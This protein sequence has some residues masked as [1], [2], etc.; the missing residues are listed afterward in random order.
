MLFVGCAI[1]SKGRT[2]GRPQGSRSKQFLDKV[3]KPIHKRVQPSELKTLAFR[4]FFQTVQKVQDNG[5]LPPE[6]A[7]E[8]TNPIDVDDPTVVND[9]CSVTD[10]LASESDEV[11]NEK[12]VERAKP[13]RNAR[14]RKRR[15]HT[16]QE[17]NNDSIELPTKRPAIQE[18]LDIWVKKIFADNMKT[19]EQNGVQIKDG[20]LWCCGK[21]LKKHKSTV[22]RHLRSKRHSRYQSEKKELESTD[23]AIKAHKAFQKMFQKNLPPGQVLSGATC[24]SAQLK[25]R[26]EYTRMMIICG[27][28]IN[29]FDKMKTY[30]RRKNCDITCSLSDLSYL[31]PAIREAELATIKKE[32][33]DTMLGSL[34]SM[35]TDGTGDDGAE[36]CNVVIRWVH[37]KTFQ[38]IQRCV[39][40]SMLGHPMT[41]ED[42]VK[43]NC[44]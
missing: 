23:R 40:L 33:S 11:G 42:I 9:T 38:P 1:M 20:K 8:K 26:V 21:E 44:I 43:V 29:K 3:C 17:K 37:V 13:H 16:V 31:I 18:P 4:N 28:P 36:M 41:A 14:P 19:F 39:L 25:E 15:I 22:C 5:N 35:F 12:P 24:S 34:Y 2:A 6:G 7:G 10:A 27:I 30:L 32:M